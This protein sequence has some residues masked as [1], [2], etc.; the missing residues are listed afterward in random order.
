[1]TAC[2]ASGL[3]AHVRT[4]APSSGCCCSGAVSAL[5]QQPASQVGAEGQN[6]TFRPI[7]QP[8]L[9]WP[10]WLLPPAQV[11]GPLGSSPGPDQWPPRQVEGRSPEWTWRGSRGRDRPDSRARAWCPEGGRGPAWGEVGWGV[12]S[13]PVRTCDPPL[14]SAD[15]CGSGEQG[16]RTSRGQGWSDPPPRTQTELIGS[17]AESTR[18]QPACKGSQVSTQGWVPDSSS[19]CTW[20]PAGLGQSR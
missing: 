12:P 5:R 7:S 1:M 9:A 8:L 2:S 20:G 6:R 17:S 10:G 16:L 19:Q 11:L 3:S 15:T 13:A 18:K 14:L 4:G